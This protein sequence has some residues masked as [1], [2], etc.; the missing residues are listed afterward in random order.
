MSV[1][2]PPPDSVELLDQLLASLFEDFETWFRR[3]LVLLDCAPES[4]LPAAERS[5]CGPI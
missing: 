1:P 4:L 3:G 5:S 2:P